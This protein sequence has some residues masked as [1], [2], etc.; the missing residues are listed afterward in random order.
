ME[1]TLKAEKYQQ[2]QRYCDL[3]KKYHIMSAAELKDH[4]RLEAEADAIIERLDDNN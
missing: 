1:R 3:C 2:K 4:A